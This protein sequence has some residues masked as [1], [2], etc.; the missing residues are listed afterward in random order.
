MSTLT[1]VRT[2]QEAAAQSRPRRRVPLSRRLRHARRHAVLVLICAVFFLPFA[3]MVLTSFKTPT[4]V[5]R[6]PPRLLPSHWVGVNYGNAIRAMPFGRYL[7]NSVLLVVLN[8]SGTLLTCPLVAY[9]LAKL[10]W[11]GRNAAF[12]VVLATMMLPPQVTMVPVYLI[13]SKLGLVDTFWPLIVPS[14]FGTPFFIFMLRQFF[15]NVPED[16][17]DAARVDGAG[18]FRIYWRIVLPLAKPA[19]ATVAVFQ[20]V[21]TWTD[22]IGPLIYLHDSGK[23]TL[24]VGLYSFFSEHGVDW[25]P[26]MAACAL[27]TLP[28][29]AIFMVAQRYFIAGIAT[30]GMK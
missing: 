28:A 30:S 8:V 25:G 4:D 5:F 1:P 6:V 3:V 7:G 13:W 14:F 15:R 11:R 24:S 29:V 18:E 23:Y 20:F 16:L 26:L 21:W 19:L 10:R 27:F 22:F 2:P 9:A 17:L 12:V